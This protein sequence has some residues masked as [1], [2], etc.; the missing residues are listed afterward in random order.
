MHLNRNLLACCVLG[1]IVS[2]QIDQRSLTE[3]AR[4][5]RSSA[6][7]TAPSTATLSPDGDTF[8]NIDATN[9]STDTTLNVYTWPDNRIANAIVMKFDLASIPGGSTISSATLNLYLDSSD[10]TI[11]PTYTVTVH[12]VINK[13]PDVS[14]ATGY[15][16]DGVNGWTASTCCYTNIPL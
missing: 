10:A 11:D 16:Y 7:V 2:C 3:V 12:Q 4:P 9:Y 14:R 13:N 8:L 6:V 15:T 5:P 1:T